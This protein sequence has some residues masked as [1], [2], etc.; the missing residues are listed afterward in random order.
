VKKKFVSDLIKNT[1]L[2]SSTIRNKTFYRIICI[3]YF[4][5][6][7]TTSVASAEYTHTHHEMK[8]L[9]LELV[10]LH[11]NLQIIFQQLLN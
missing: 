4:T 2:I 11:I 5:F 3:R 1:I 9:K 10:F 6:I 8:P 7:K